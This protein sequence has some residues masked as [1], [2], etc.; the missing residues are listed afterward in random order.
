[1][2]YFLREALRQAWRQRLLSLVAVS[3]LGL[4]ALFAGAWGLL[5]RNS[6]HWQAELGVAA[7]VSAYL[8]PGLGAVGQGAAVDAAR[9]LS[10]VVQVD[11][12]SEA[13]AAEQLSQDPALKQ[14]LALLGENPLPA[15]LKVRLADPKP[16]AAAALAT[17]L[18]QVPGVEE[19]DA[20]AGAVEGILKASSAARSALLG[21]GALFSAVAVLIV[22][23][24]LRLAAW[25]RRQELG[26]MR[27]VGASHT[28]IRAPF[29]LEGALQGA[30]AGGLAALA[31]RGSLAWLALQLRRDLQ[32]DLASFLPVNVDLSLGLSLFGGGILLGGLG[33][34]LALST[35]TLAYEGEDA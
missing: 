33:A 13:Q 17:A 3:A 8:R 6:Q 32:W 2:S 21:L 14:A 23:A 19:V 4:A 16:A 25:S 18:A 30:L 29:L 1:V 35:V 22:A 12:V 9:A 31:L 15:T 7:Q 27:L 26:I 10:G 20:G 11:L 5:W 24:V 28:F 34:L